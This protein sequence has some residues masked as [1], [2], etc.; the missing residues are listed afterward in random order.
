MNYI[1]FEI[2]SKLRGFKFGIGFLG[3]IMKHYNVDLLGFGEL[4]TKN[5]FSATP[6]ILYFGHYHNC[7]RK[8][9][10]ITFTIHD[11][12]DWVDAIENPLND[13]NLV[14]ATKR[15][16]D[17]ITKYLPKVEEEEKGEKKS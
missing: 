5:P 13:A 9:A 2:G 12:E 4:L 11:V 14:E 1:E 17:S 8:G 16:I 6:A 3:D 10:P 15:C 7:V